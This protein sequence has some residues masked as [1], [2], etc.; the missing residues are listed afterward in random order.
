[1]LRELGTIC[2]S[3]PH[4]DL[5]LQWDVCNE[6]IIWDGQKWELVSW[7]RP[8]REEILE[9]MRRVCESVP[10]DVELGIHLCYGDFGG[11][12]FADPV[13]ATHM[14]EFAN[15]LTRTIRHSLAYIHMPVP[16]S[17]TEDDFFKPLANLVC[18]SGT[19]IYLGLIHAADGVEGVR[20]RVALAEK[21][22]PKFGIATECGFARART[23]D[24]VNSLIAIHAESSCEPGRL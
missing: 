20:K 21:Y 2:R 6:M 12:H 3:I 9:R 8:T 13:D 11:K 15:A 18:P 1:M 7:V 14:V 10:P 16:L 22:L 4:E 24:V 17:R 23:E 19:E 5:C